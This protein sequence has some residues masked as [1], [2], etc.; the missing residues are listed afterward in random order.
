MTDIP[1][2]LDTCLRALLIAVSALATAVAALAKSVQADRRSKRIG[3]ELR[4]HNRGA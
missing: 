2:L 4:G 1:D 3:G